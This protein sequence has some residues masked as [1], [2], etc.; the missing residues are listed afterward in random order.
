[1]ELHREGSVPAACVAGLFN[2]TQMKMAQLS[3]T[4]PNVC[5]IGEVFDGLD[6]IFLTSLVG[7]HW[8]TG[9]LR[10]N[11]SSV[12]GRLIVFHFSCSRGIKY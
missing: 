2:Y 10:V 6:K 1:M 12:N 4:S 11:S 8:A 7:N 9:G 3:R 5:S